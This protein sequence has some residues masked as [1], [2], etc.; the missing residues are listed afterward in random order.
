MHLA[1]RVQSEEFLVVTRIKLRDVLRPLLFR[2]PNFGGALTFFSARQGKDRNPSS[3]R[4]EKRWEQE[5]E[6]F[7]FKKYRA[8]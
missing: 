2:I 4:N 7:P 6:G 8:L 1:F 5:R 3:C